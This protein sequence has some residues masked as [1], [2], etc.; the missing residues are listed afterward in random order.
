MEEDYGFTRYFDTDAEE[1]DTC[2]CPTDN[3]LGQ[4]IKCDCDYSRE[5]YDY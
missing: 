1:C 5:E 4:R 3:G 2:G